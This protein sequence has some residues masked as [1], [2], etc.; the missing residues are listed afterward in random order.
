MPISRIAAAVEV[1]EHLLGERCRRRRHRRGALADRRLRAHLAAGMERLAEDAVEQ[2][3]RRARL[4][5]GA[6]LAENLAL[7]RDERVEAG[8]DAEEVQR[9]G[10]IAQAIERG[11]D[12]RLELRER[13]DRAP[14]GLVRVLGH[15]VELG[16]IARREA[17][18]LAELARP[19]SPRPRGRARRARAARPARDGARCRRERGASCEVGHREREPDEDDEREAGERDV[20]GAAAGPARCSAARDRRPRRPR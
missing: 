17:D 6:H 2:L 3:R 14:L 9:G 8:R 19:A 13:G 11:L 12:L 18:G 16:A 5:G 7:A 4:V 1:A 10:L 15:D 20:G